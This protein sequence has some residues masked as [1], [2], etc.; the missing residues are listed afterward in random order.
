MILIIIETMMAMMMLVMVCKANASKTSKSNGSKDDE[1]S[2]Q[3]RDMGICQ[4]CC[5]EKHGM[6]SKQFQRATDTYYL[7]D[8]DNAGIVERIIAGKTA[9]DINSGELFNSLQDAIKEIAPFEM[10]KVHRQC[11][12]YAE[13]IVYDLNAGKIRRKWIQWRRKFID[14]YGWLWQ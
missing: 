1:S 2:H 6:T 12:Y 5:M 10:R 13:H 7:C 3:F 9:K 11:P 14:T 4:R 8:A